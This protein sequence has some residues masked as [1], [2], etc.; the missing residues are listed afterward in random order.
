[1]PYRPW[2]IPTYL[3]ACLLS[4]AIYIWK[5][6]VKPRGVVV[7]VRTIVGPEGRGR[8]PDLPRYSMTIRNHY[9]RQEFDL[10][11][12]PKLQCKAEEEE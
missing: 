5:L 6:T 9:A 12:F 4:S 2:Q 3:H 7:P 8:C 1:M 10:E 11:D